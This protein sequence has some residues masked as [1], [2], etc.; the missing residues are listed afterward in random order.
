MSCDFSQP[1]FHKPKVKNYRDF[2]KAHNL[3]MPYTI[4]V[5]ATG[6]CFGFTDDGIKII[7]SR[8]WLEGITVYPPN[9]PTIFIRNDGQVLVGDEIELRKKIEPESIVKRNSALLDEDSPA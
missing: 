9:H 2:T 6:S 8:R 3:R 5:L 1:V 4:R 7:Q